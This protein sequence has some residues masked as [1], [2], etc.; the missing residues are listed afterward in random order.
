MEWIILAGRVAGVW[1]VKRNSTLRTGW[2]R[3]TVCQRTFWNVDKQCTEDKSHFLHD[4]LFSCHWPRLSDKLRVKHVLP[5]L[6]ILS[7]ANRDWAS[8]THIALT[9][10]ITLPKRK[11]KKKLSFYSVSLISSLEQNQCLCETISAQRNGASERNIVQK[12][13]VIRKLWP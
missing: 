4:K 13:C 5:D 10:L 7:L 9:Q 2:Q 8:N 12:R 6:C 11:E 1:G 3:R